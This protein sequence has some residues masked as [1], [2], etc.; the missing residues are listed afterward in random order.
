MSKEATHYY[1][2][3]GPELNT[4]GYQLKDKIF[5]GEI[6]DTVKRVETN[7]ELPVEVSKDHKNFT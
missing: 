7:D 3:E 5:A 2:Y 1:E 6:D 4:I